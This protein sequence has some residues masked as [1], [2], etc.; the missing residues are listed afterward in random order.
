VVAGGGL[1]HK[2]AEEDLSKLTDDEINSDKLIINVLEIPQLP[3]GKSY[4]IEYEL[5]K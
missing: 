4:K 1:S 5:K 2:N 3:R